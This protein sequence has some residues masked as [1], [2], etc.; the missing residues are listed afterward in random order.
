MVA[1]ETGSLHTYQE[2]DPVHYEQIGWDTLRATVEELAEEAEKWGVFLGLEGV[3]THTLSTPD[4]MRRI[5][6]EV[7]STCIGVVFDPCNLIGTAIHLQDQIV[8]DS[9]RLFGD[10]MIMAHLKDIY[11]DGDKIYHGKA[12][13]G[14]FHT[15]AFLNKLQE[16]KPMIDVSLEDIQ[17]ME[18]NETIA[19]LKKL[20]PFTF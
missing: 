6:D 14:R 8:E 15:G 10:R 2:Q 7:P 1:T 20:T 5:L 19:T 11:Q 9:F 12:G 16:Y 4:K 18:I 3:S 17:A 13:H